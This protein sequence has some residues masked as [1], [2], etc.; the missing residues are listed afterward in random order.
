MGWRSILSKPLAKYI[1]SQ[2]EKDL[3]LA[4]Q[5]QK[6]LLQELLKKGSNTEF[7]KKHQFVKIR[8]YREYRAAVPIRDYEAFRPYIDRIVEGYPNVLWPGVPLYF[9]KTSGTT[10][11]AKYIPISK[12]SISNHINGARNALLNYIHVTGKTGFTDGKMIFL[13]GSPELETH[14]EIPSGR[15]S[16]IV[17][18]HVPAILRSNQLPT[19][20]TNGISIWQRKLDAIISETTHEDMRLISGIPPWVQM[21]FDQIVERTGKTII[22][23]FPNFSLMVHGGVNF[24]PYKKKLTESIGAEIDMLE[25]YPASEGFFAYEDFR[26]EGLRLNINSGIF[27]EFVP[28]NQIHSDSPER[29]SLGEV[30]LGEDYALIVTSNAGLW[31]YNIGDLVR[32]TSVDPYRIIVSGR[33][34]HFINAFGEHVIDK[35]VS[36]AIA[37]AGQHTGEAINEFTVAPNMGSD[38][39]KPFHEWFIEFDEQPKDLNILEGFIEREVR[40]QNAYYD[41]LIK[42]EILAPLRIVALRQGSFHQL[43]EQKGKLGGQNKIPHLA[44]DRRWVELW[45][46]SSNTK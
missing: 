4:V 35:E 1:C 32:F 10:S 7:G 6:Q 5:L 12:A 11:G 43:M 9:A 27:Y 2:E 24:A 25:L 41:D 29:L 13:S 31:S 19:P 36:E 22:E 39:Q 37:L 38:S 28:V 14:G 20:R 34:E 33:V 26:G 15:L 42:G 8:T 44:N 3:S 46:S 16:G 23:S 21:Y 17:N 18:H 40:R 45:S 30:Q